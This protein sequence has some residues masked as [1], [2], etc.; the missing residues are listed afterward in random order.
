MG[1]ELSE[2]EAQSTVGEDVHGG[3]SQRTVLIEFLY[4]PLTVGIRTR[5]LRDISAGWMIGN[6]GDG[7]RASGCPPLDPEAG[8][9]S[10]RTTCEPRQKLTPGPSDGVE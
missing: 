5:K 7:R 10:T 6:A 9:T 8:A 4:L 2:S 1:W 3:W